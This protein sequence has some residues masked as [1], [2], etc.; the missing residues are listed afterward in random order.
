MIASRRRVRVGGWLKIDPKS[1]SAWLAWRSD[2]IGERKTKVLFSQ[3]SAGDHR[4]VAMHHAT[5]TLP[6]LA[7]WCA[8][9]VRRYCVCGVDAS[10]LRQLQR[11]TPGNLA[12]SQPSRRGTI[13]IME[14]YTKLADA[15]DNE[16]RRI[17]Q[18]YSFWNR[19]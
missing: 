6:K 2:R 14:S 16:R 1:A 19:R 10:P 5:N 9:N 13:T 17:D 8:A 7:L 15:L 3:I 12:A 18:F 4:E 11:L